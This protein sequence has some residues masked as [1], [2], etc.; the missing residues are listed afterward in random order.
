[1]MGVSFSIE[2]QIALLPP[3]IE[4]VEIPVQRA[5]VAI[6]KR[7]RDEFNLNVRSAF[8]KWLAVECTRKLREMGL[9]D[10]LL[11]KLQA[12]GTERSLNDFP[13][14]ILKST[15]DH[16][17]PLYLGGTN[18]FKNLCLMP[19]AINTFKFKLELHQ[20]YNDPAATIIK[21]IVPIKLN[22]VYDPLPIFPKHF[23]EP[24]FKIS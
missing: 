17:V 14:Q 1:M 16:I 4:I 19:K 24:G 7:L 18:D 2:E 13:V 3:C 12:Y 9:D 22:D 6:R 21:T 20:L 11:A 15:V 5:D 8:F 23:Y 10:F